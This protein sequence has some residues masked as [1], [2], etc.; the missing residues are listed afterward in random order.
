[1]HHVNCVDAPLRSSHVILGLL[2]ASNAWV[3][4]AQAGEPI[5]AGGDV[6]IYR[7]SDSGVDLRTDLAGAGR[8]WADDLDLDLPAGEPCELVS[9]TVGFRALQD[10]RGMSAQ[11]DL[12][13]FGALSPIAGTQFHF[14][15]DAVEPNATVQKTVYFPP[16]IMLPDPVY[17]SW[18][19]LT[20]GF[21]P[22]FADGVD[23]GGNAAGFF[24]IG[25]GGWLPAAPAQQSPPFVHAEIVCRTASS[26]APCAIIRGSN[27]ANCIIDARRPHPIYDPATREGWNEFEVFFEGDCDS[28]VL[29]D[30]GFNVFTVPDLS[31][32]P[33]IKEAQLTSNS[34]RITFA[35][36]IPPGQWTCIRH[37]LMDERACLGLLPGDVD[38]SRRSTLADVTALIDALNGVR[39]FP[40]HSTD[41]NR[42][43]RA[44][45]AD[46]T[47]FFNLHNGAGDFEP[48]REVELLPVCPGER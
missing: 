21:G 22:L 33:A 45:A 47:E 4:F 31:M 6:V 7:S 12:R 38:S 5:V 48:W 46:I 18:E 44:N 34:V 36:P 37:T 30:I 1:M 29:A 11:V 9:V 13:D 27:P 42:T 28:N 8:H 10:S 15:A 43:G 19:Q 35:E 26:F 23:I 24:E 17:L 40:L 41:L 39:N 14:L 20:D 32:A 16:G 3:Q 25:P 2:I